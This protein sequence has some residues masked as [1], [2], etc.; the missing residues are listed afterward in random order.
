MAEFETLIQ[1]EEHCILF[2]LDEQFSILMLGT[3]HA[4]CLLSFQVVNCS[5]CVS[6]V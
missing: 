4:I 6:H 1:Q 5:H 2:G 3:Q